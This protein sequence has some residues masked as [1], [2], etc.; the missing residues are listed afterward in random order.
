MIERHLL[1][2]RARGSIS[3]QEEAAIRATV[4]GCRQVRPHEI[5]VRS[6]V[7]LDSCTLLLSGLATQLKDLRDG[8]RQMTAL[9]VPG[10]FMDLHGLTLKRLDHDVL[11][12]S[13][14]AVAT[15]PHARI[16]ELIDAFP[17]LARIYWSA[18]SLDAAVHREWELSLGRRNA[19]ERMAHLFCELHARLGVVGLVEDE[20]Y[21]CHLTQA[22][23]SECLGLT[24]VHVNRTL[25]HLRESGLLEFRKC[26]VRIRDMERLRA[27][28]DFDPGYLYLD[29]RPW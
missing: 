5:I 29:R 7:R 2:L 19:L 23:L 28:A 4:T 22:E 10:D 27:I 17:R 3:C 13:R 25:M 14:C 26:R 6:H 12:L 24:A 1:N 21:E 8:R 9:H 20:G 18:T 16:L 11:A 15:A